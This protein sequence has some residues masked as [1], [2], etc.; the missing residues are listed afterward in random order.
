[1]SP[2][3]FPERCKKLSSVLSAVRNYVAIWV[4]E[5]FRPLMR[6]SCRS[7]LMPGVTDRSACIQIATRGV[8]SSTCSGLEAVR[9]Y[10]NRTTSDR[11]I[12]I[13]CERL[14]NR[15]PTWKLTDSHT[16]I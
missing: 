6:T 13:G 5:A 16:F 4:A 3:L 2:R 12:S 8:Q 1:V 14:P 15:S 11:A 10:S 7:R 9:V